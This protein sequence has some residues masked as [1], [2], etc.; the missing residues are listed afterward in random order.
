MDHGYYIQLAPTIG[1]DLYS[2][3]IGK[4][5]NMTSKFSNDQVEQLRQA[6]EKR[7][8]ELRWEIVNLL[9]QSEKEN[10]S[11][12]AGQVHDAGDESVANMLVDINYS[13]VDHLVQEIGAVER[14]L[15]RIPKGSYGTCLD[16]D[17][18]I[19]FARLEAE[20]F[21]ERCIECQQRFE[22]EHPGSGRAGL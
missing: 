1:A 20:P 2:K 15:M 4:P 10:F 19:A 3:N 21:A 16:C 18:A 9:N 5:G 12:I 17:E 6:L 13:T 7:Y 14:A 22:R 11:E 8:N